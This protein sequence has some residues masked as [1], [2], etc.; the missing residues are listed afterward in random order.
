MITRVLNVLLRRTLHSRKPFVLEGPRGA[1]KTTLLRSELPHFRYITLEDSSDRLGARRDPVRFLARL[2]LPTIIDDAHRVPALAKD[3]LT[4]PRTVILASSRKLRSPLTTLRL[5][6]PTQAELQQRCSIRLEVFG[7]FA[8]APALAQKS[9]TSFSYPV[10]LSERDVRDLISVHDLDRFESF[11]AAALGFSGQLLHQQ[12][13]AN[14]AGVSRT[15]AIRWL[16]VLDAC[17]LTLVI[18]CYPDAFSRRIVKAPKIHFLDSNN[19]E[20]RVIWELY[21]N[22]VHSGA[23]PRFYHWRDS[24]GLEIPLLLLLDQDGLPVPMTISEKATPVVEARLRS[25]MRLAKVASGAIFTAQEFRETQR[26][27]VCWYHWSQL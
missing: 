26:G 6:P 16:E 15:T 4:H 8:S 27:G 13:I 11:Y 21:R 20:S 18:P 12:E 2:R 5:Y 24:N 19:F 1:G 7:R 17:F 14:C 25:F 23:E 9:L 3:L 22:A 10:G